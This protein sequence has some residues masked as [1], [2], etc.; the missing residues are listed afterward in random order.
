MIDP[1]VLLDPF[2]DDAP[3]G[4]D[5][6]NP[7]FRPEYTD[8]RRA[9]S[10]ARQ[11]AENAVA[12]NPPDW[13]DVIERCGGILMQQSKDMEVAAWLAEALAYADGPA[14][15]ADGAAVIKGLVDRFWTGLFPAPFT[16]EPDV[17]AEEARLRPLKSLVDDNGRLAAAVRQTV[18]FSLDD[19]TQFTYKDCL[20]SKGMK[21]EDRAKRIAALQ[22]AQRA[23]FE[24]T[25]AGRSWEDLV[26]E[27]RPD[28]GQFIAEARDAAGAALAGWTAVAAAVSAQNGGEAFSCKPVTDL[29]THMRRLLAEIVPDAGAGKD[30]VP[31]IAAEAET[32]TAPPVPAA[33]ATPGAVATR[34]DALRQLEEIAAFFRRTE[35][36]SPVAY[37][38]EEAARRAKL[39]WPEWLTEAV[40][41]QQQRRFILERLGLQPEVH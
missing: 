30:S 27:L 21:P 11:R 31:G 5:L 12:E 28:P 15:L 34:A 4:I 38:L 20:T 19:G 8:A 40:P 10:N 41:D 23:E 2:P 39:S 16:D 32:M 37:T 24:K 36:Y 22:P 29:L 9:S 3:A 14:G 1:E 18:L 7:N 33:P 25:P 13:D 6:R 17:S 26:Q 35:P